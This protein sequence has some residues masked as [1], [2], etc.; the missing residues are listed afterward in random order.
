M[1]EKLSQFA[2]IQDV[3]SYLHVSWIQTRSHCV[4]LFYGKTECETI[5]GSV[6]AICKLTDVPKAQIDIG[7]VVYLAKKYPNEKFSLSANPEI[8]EILEISNK[9]IN[10]II[11]QQ[12]VQAIIN[13]NLSVW[14]GDDKAL[15]LQVQSI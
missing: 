14:N 8:D 4:L 5:L 10:V 3:L 1:V 9:I 2:Q 12:Q 15:I 11:N 6:Q 13:Q 7:K